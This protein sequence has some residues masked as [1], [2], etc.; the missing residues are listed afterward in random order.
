MAIPGEDVDQNGISGATIVNTIRP[1]R[2]S[3]LT[4][5]H[6]YAFRRFG[7]GEEVSIFGV[8]QAELSGAPFAD[9]GSPRGHGVVFDLLE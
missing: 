9:F 4:E 3:L 7:E 5:R 2:I 6:W 1:G 8:L